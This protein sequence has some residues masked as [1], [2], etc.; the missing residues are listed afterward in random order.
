MDIKGKHITALVT[1]AQSSDFTYD[2]LS[3]QDDERSHLMT[4]VHV[5]NSGT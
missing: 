3:T 5:L 2:V 1:N 4:G